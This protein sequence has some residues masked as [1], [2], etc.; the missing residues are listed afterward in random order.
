[1]KVEAEIN[2]NWLFLNWSSD[3][4]SLTE[5]LTQIW[6]QYYLGWS[7]TLDSKAM[8]KTFF[9]IFVFRERRNRF[10]S[11]FEYNPE[12]IRYFHIRIFSFKMYISCLLGI[13][14]GQKKCKIFA[15]TFSPKSNIRNTFYFVSSINTEII[16]Y[17]LIGSK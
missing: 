8:R 14:E 7:N 1:M 16:A 2:S 15:K 13:S 3:F 4:E 5:S 17:V 6:N 12:Y 11:I 9:R 10:F